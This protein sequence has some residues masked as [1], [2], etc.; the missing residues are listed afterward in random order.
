MELSATAAK[1]VRTTGSFIT[2]GFEI[3][4]EVQAAGF[5]A[6]GAN[7][8]A[9]VKAVTALELTVHRTVGTSAAAPAC[10]IVVGLPSRRAW[11]NDISTPEIGHPY[12]E[13]QFIPGPSKQISVGPGGMVEYRP[14]YQ[15]QVHVPANVGAVAMRRY[16]SGLLAHFPPRL[17]L[18]L[19]DGSVLRVRTD[20]GPF[21]G[22]LKQSKPGWVVAPVTFPLLI[23]VPNTI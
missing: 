21:G 22:Q 16:A 18:P 17:A 1:Y 9:T 3:G 11:E 6:A 2:D 19:V 23:H 10:S 14:M 15:L 12:V 5:T 4:L 13:E 20:V 8:Y 7:G